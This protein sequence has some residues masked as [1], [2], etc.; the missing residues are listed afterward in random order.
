MSDRSTILIADDHEDAL[1]AYSLILK[2]EGYDVLSATT[3]ED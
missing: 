2:S 1:L 3:G